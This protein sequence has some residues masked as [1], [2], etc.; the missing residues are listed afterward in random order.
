[1]FGDDAVALANNP[2]VSGNPAPVSFHPS[3]AQNGIGGLLQHAPFAF[4][5]LTQGVRPYLDQLHA[6]YGGGRLPWGFPLDKSVHYVVIHCLPGLYAPLFPGETPPGID[7]RNGLPVNGETWPFVLKDRE[8]LQGTS[9]LDT[10]L[11]A[12][13]RATAIL[14]VEGLSNTAT[15]H[16]WS[17]ID[18]LTVRGARSDGGLMS[19]ANASGAGILIGDSVFG[20]T[21]C[22]VKISNC[23]LVDNAVGLAVDSGGG[24]PFV[25][26]TPLIVNNTFARN[27]IG[28][29][30]GN[31]QGP[32]PNVGEARLILL[33]KRLRLLATGPN[34]RWTL[35]GRRQR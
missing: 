22:Q 10:V 8:S 2:G 15:S 14:Q 7:P 31:R 35:R 23:F 24:F 28:V 13:G 27:A 9:A 20:N 5:T 30:N 18:S 4:R 19:R 29:W 16:T 33:N 11:D 21:G 1:L 32:N 26:H 6:A 25:P 12:R 34:A 3:A 17:F